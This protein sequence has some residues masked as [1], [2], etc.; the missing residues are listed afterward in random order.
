MS[1]SISQSFTA[2]GPGITSSFLANGGTG[3]YTYSVLG[4]GAGGSIDGTTGVYTAPG[5]VPSV[6]AMVYDT[7][8]AQ[9]SLSATVTAQVLVGLPLVLFC[10]IIQHE[11]GLANGRVYLWDQKI[12]QPT[13]SGLYIA[14]GVMSCK[15]FGNI[16]SH[17]GSGSGLTSNQFVSMYAMLSVDI[18]SRGPAARD[19]KEEIILALNSDYAQSQQEANSFY[20]GRLPAGGQFVNLS[21]VD[22]AAIPY[23]FNI[24]VAIQYAFVKP[25]DVAYMHTFEPVEVTTEP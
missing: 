5:V 23:R 11:M 21:N 14:I 24:S 15:P 12:M 22:G 18:I 19:R 4:G 2:V 25:T 16:N 7:I 10:D 6:P 20:I 8:Q 3:P 13:D 9:D 17:D 1:L